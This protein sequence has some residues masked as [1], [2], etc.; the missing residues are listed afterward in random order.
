MTQP[1][2]A[3]LSATA[4]DGP[5]CRHS[6]DRVCYVAL[7]APENAGFCLPKNWEFEEGQICMP[8]WMER[9]PRSTGRVFATAKG[10]G[11]GSL[12]RVPGAG[13]AGASGDATIAGTAA[14][15]AIEITEQF[16]SGASK[17][18]FAWREAKSPRPRHATPSVLSA[19]LRIVAVG[20]NMGKPGNSGNSPTF[21]IISVG[22]RPHRFEPPQ[23]RPTDRLSA[24]N[25]LTTLG[26]DSRRLAPIPAR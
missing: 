24:T 20:I 4:G 6:P 16:S 5:E 1:A 3:Y 26:T 25:A 15:R 8:A 22:S 7:C 2:V 9:W 10:T 12:P 13:G 19:G 11:G 18:L 21:S 23:P 14:G 17:S